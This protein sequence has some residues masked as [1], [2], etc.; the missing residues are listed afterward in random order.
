[1]RATEGRNT[2]AYNVL[3][4]R[5]YPKRVSNKFCIRIVLLEELALSLN[6]A[7]LVSYATETVINLCHGKRSCE[8]S[9]DTGT[10][11]SPCRPDSRMYLKVVYTCGKL[12]PCP[13][14]PANTHFPPIFPNKLF[15]PTCAVPRMVLKEE[16]EGQ[17]EPDEAEFNTH[18]ID[19]DDGEVDYDSGKEYIRESAASPSAS[20]ADGKTENQTKTNVIAESTDLK[21]GPGAGMFITF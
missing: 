14:P 18:V 17:L 11:G 20:N 9:A 15:T 7:C 5:E 12:T 4:P 6:A 16:Y 3:N 2:R 19:D 13:L 21:Q 8:V 1:M 10:F